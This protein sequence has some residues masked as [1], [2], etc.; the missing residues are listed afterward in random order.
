[1]LKV[2]RIETNTECILA[3]IVVVHYSNYFVHKRF[4][5]RLHLRYNKTQV[6]S[7]CV[8]CTFSTDFSSLKQEEK[9]TTSDMEKCSGTLI[10]LGIPRW[11]RP[12][13]SERRDGDVTSNR[14]HFALFSG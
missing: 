6:S 8:F 2:N 4:V 10:Q 1:M 12:M 13:F 9:N 11:K 14:F 5:I 7:C 3:A